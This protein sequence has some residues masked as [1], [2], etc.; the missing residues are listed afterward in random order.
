MNIN[1]Q[2]SFK[3]TS[4]FLAMD[5]FLFFFINAQPTYLG[6]C[7]DMPVT[8]SFHRKYTCTTGF[9]QHIFSSTSFHIHEDTHMVGTHRPSF[10]PLYRTKKKTPEMSITNYTIAV[11]VI[12]KPVKKETSYYESLNNLLRNTRIR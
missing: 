10:L 7:Y 4:P 8:F 3:I 6:T 11:I 2:F 9:F 5:V 12:K 1:V